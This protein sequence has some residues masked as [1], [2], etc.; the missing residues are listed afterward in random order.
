[1]ANF[2]LPIDQKTYDGLASAGLAEGL[3]S[4]KPVEVKSPTGPTVLELSGSDLDLYR[5]AHRFLQKT[6]DGFVLASDNIYFS[7]KQIDSCVEKETGGASINFTA[8]QLKAIQRITAG[9]IFSGIV[10]Q[11]HCL[12]VSRLIG[13]N[14]IFSR[15]YFIDKDNDPKTTGDIFPL[16]ASVYQ[17]LRDSL[18]LV[19]SPGV[20]KDTRL[21]DS[22]D[23]EEAGF[24]FYRPVL[25]NRK[26]G[27]TDFLKADLTLEQVQFGAYTIPLGYRGATQDEI[28]KFIKL[29]KNA[30]YFPMG[31][32]PD[33]AQ[34][35]FRL[36]ESSTG[37]LFPVLR[38]SSVSECVD[39]SDFSQPP[40]LGFFL[41]YRLSADEVSSLAASMGAEA[42][43]VC[44]FAGPDDSEYKKTGKRLHRFDVHPSLLQ[45]I[46]RELETRISAAKSGKV[47]MPG[48]AQ[49]STETA[50]A[51][52]TAFENVH[53]GDTNA[54]NRFRE[55][56]P[57]WTAT[58]ETMGLILQALLFGATFA[59][60][61]R[62]FST[63]RGAAVDQTGFTK[64]VA[65]IE[66]ADAKTR[67]WFKE[68][69]G[70]DMTEEARAGKYK[71]LVPDM[72][73]VETMIST[74]TRD[75]NTGY[76]E[77][78]PSG[79]GKSTDFMILADQIAKGEAGPLNG[80]KVMA[81]RLSNVVA[82]GDGKQGGFEAAMVGLLAQAERE[83][84]VVFFDEAVLIKDIGTHAG[85]ERG[86]EVE[87]LNPLA[88][89]RVRAGYA[90]TDV[91]FAKQFPLGEEDPLVRRCYLDRRPPAEEAHL[92]KVLAKQVEKHRDLSGIEITPEALSQARMRGI[93]VLRTAEPSRSIALLD[94]AVGF[95]QAQKRRQ[96]KGQLKPDEKIYTSVTADLIDEIV[97]RK[98]E[99][100]RN[101]QVAVLI[102]KIQ[103]E[104]DFALDKGFDLQIARKAFERGFIE[105][106][107]PFDISRRL[108]RL[109]GRL[110]HFNLLLSDPE[111]PKI[112][113]ARALIGMREFSAQGGYVEELD[114][115]GPL[116]DTEPAK[117]DSVPQRAVPPFKVSREELRGVFPELSKPF[118]NPQAVE[119]ALLSSAS[120]AEVLNWRS[121]FAE[122]QLPESALEIL[123][124]MEWRFNSGAMARVVS[125]LLSEPAAGSLSGPGLGAALF[126]S[127][128]A[129]LR[130]PM[131]V[132]EEEGLQRTIVERYLALEEEK[133][134][135]GEELTRTARM[136]LEEQ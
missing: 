85:R 63:N 61:G 116:P 104:L 21:L 42:K 97:N 111:T 79:A 119:A 43:Q 76:F 19:P 80:V 118:A 26:T 106:E 5:F 24:H 29:P 71:Y 9:K 34:S 46:I 129:H 28:K 52:K 121:L 109:S 130:A 18:A 122:G 31:S 94:G 54:L 44:H 60:L 105:G 96:T 68:L 45:N 25:T 88:E 86:A 57:Y 114:R 100:R 84:A 70:V 59:Y 115:S 4:L 27:K 39:K 102:D 14:P 125:Q 17:G 30:Q 136:R 50:T 77:V 48:G 74:F 90:T 15:V 135:R 82:F 35:Q 49:W 58:G 117:A 23:E 47:E 73:V 51:L 53:R 62:K 6:E 1:M 36:T 64:M 127:T 69:G 91:E 41:D 8:E 134:G 92:K 16:D 10:P 131:P 38:L 120:E 99:D 37:A 89:G 95:I 110:E 108:D 126:R 12:A 98:K 55:A 32:P 22:T 7:Q 128:T 11:E 123:Q 67:D 101:S 132:S 107:S 124:R 3:K 113:I 87:M 72:E 93:E 133:A 2:T 66:K 112:E 103:T 65:E 56:H 81:I 13:S 40:S 20:F 33:L 78:R 83:G 75:Q